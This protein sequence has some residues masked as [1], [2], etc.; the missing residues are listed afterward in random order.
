VRAHRRLLLSL[1]AVA[2]LAALV[3]WFTGAAEELLTFAPFLLMTAFLLAGRFLGERWI[4]ARMR[5]ASPVRKHRPERWTRGR[6]RSLAALLE[7][8]PRLLRGPPAAAVPQG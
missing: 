8:S 4:A 1:S 6:E 2:V 3:H 5:S 7:R